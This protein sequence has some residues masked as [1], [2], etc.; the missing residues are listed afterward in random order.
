MGLGF[1]AEGATF[2]WAIA[3]N[4]THTDEARGFKY[5]VSLRAFP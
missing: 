1:R 3:D 5:R 4:V 2:T